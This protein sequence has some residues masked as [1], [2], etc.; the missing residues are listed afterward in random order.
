MESV[1]DI[2]KPCSLARNTMKIQM[3]D[4]SIDD[5]QEL[6]EC[7]NIFFK[8]KVENLASEIKKDP[9]INTF[10]QLNEKIKGSN[11]KFKLKTVKE[12]V[13]LE[14]IKSLKSKRSHG[15]DGISSEFL[16]LGAEVLVVPL[17]FIINYSIL[18]GKFPPQWKV[19]KIYPL[20]KNGDK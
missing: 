18:T 2:L 1:N 10:S 16:K 9:T 20:H 14:I 4:K 5:T 3:E 12:E 6:A 11:L 19:T 13:V 7:F 8:E 15:C 17:T